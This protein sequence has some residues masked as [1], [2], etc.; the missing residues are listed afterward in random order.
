MSRRNDE[1]FRIYQTLS[2]KGSSKAPELSETA[3]IN[4]EIRE[5]IGLLDLYNALNQ[6]KQYQIEREALIHFGRLLWPRTEI[7]DLGFL[8]GEGVIRVQIGKNRSNKR[9]GT[10][11]INSDFEEDL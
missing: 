8:L 4:P 9:S 11:T 10:S 1:V 5:F 3:C 7:S 2:E 6:T